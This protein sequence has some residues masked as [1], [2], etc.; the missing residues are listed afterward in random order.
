VEDYFSQLLNVH[1]VR[2]V[3]EMEIQTAQPLVPEPSLFVVEITVAQLKRYEYKSPG[4]DQILAELIQ[5]GKKH[6]VLRSINSLI[7]FGIRK[8]CHGSGRSLLLYQF[9]RWVINLTTNCWG[10]LLFYT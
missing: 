8:N 2:D 10:I 6:Y 4:I 7:L 9:T 1:R 5:A 3:R